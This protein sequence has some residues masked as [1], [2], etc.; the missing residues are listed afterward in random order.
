M[1]GVLAVGLAGGQIMLVDLCLINC[2][3]GTVMKHHRRL[4]V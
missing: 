2:D 4:F 3:D 1:N